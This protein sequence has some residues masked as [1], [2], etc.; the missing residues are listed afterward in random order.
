[1]DGD[2]LASASH[3]SWIPVTDAAMTGGGSRIDMEVVTDGSRSG[4][5]LRLSGT[6]VA[7]GFAGAWVGLDQGSRAMDLA[8]FDA[9]RL[10]MRGAGAWAVGLRCSGK[11]WANFVAPVQGT[12]AWQTIEVP[13]RK[14]V[15]PPAKGSSAAPVFDAH[16]ARWLGIQPAAG[17]TG[18]FAVEVDDVELV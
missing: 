9:I 5:A 12:A 4:K 16:E 10:R 7:E 8:A 14:M 1:E 11:T 6:V 13:F 3:L 2:R 18:A 17:R 15:A